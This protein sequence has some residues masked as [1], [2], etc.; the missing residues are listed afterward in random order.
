MNLCTEMMSIKSKT[1][2]FDL[3]VAI[4]KVNRTDHMNYWCLHK[5]SCWSIQKMDIW[6]VFCMWK[7]CIYCQTERSFSALVFKAEHH[8]CIS[9]VLSH[10]LNL[11]SLA[12]SIACVCILLLHSQTRQDSYQSFQQEVERAA[13]F[14]AW[15]TTQIKAFKPSSCLISI[16]NSTNALPPWYGCLPVGKTTW[17][18]VDN[19]HN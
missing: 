14:S 12:D 4:G 7:D 11:S 3:L 8:L 2:R 5:M 17:C 15:I 18:E 16:Q 6:V 10:S 9:H 13:A 1:E 19:R